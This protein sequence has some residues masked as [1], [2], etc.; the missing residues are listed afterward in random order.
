MWWICDLATPLVLLLDWLSLP[1]FNMMTSS[2][3]NIVRVTGH[4]CRE[5]ACHRW[6]PRTKGSDAEL[7]CFLWSAPWINGWV[8]DSDAGDLRLHRAHYDI[9]VMNTNVFK[10]VCHYDNQAS[11]NMLEMGDSRNLLAKSA[12]SLKDSEWCDICFAVM[13]FLQIKAYH[14]GIYISWYA[15]THKQIIVAKGNMYHQTLTNY[16]EP[17]D[18]VLLGQK[19]LYNLYNF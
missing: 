5:F 17:E 10:I 19:C 2:N 9:T 8:N 3:G 15:L 16:K 1:R 4:W 12:Y 13:F 14:K 6:I 7:W 18:F 11:I